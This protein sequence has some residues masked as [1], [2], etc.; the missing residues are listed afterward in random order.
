MR[1]RS[2]MSAGDAAEAATRP[3]IPSIPTKAPNANFSWLK[4]VIWF[5]A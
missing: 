3:I 1:W 2:T 5:S 4:S